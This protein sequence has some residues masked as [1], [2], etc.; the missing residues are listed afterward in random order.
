MYLS[1]A[2]QPKLIIG[3][4]QDMM[5]TDIVP[6]KYYRCDWPIG[7][8]TCNQSSYYDVNHDGT[9]DFYVFHAFVE[10]NLSSYR[11][12]QV[13]PIGNVE[14]LIDSMGIT[15]FNKGD[16]I[17]S[18]SS[19]TVD[20]IYTIVGYD[21]ISNPIFDTAYLPRS[22]WWLDTSHHGWE[23]TS[24]A[25]TGGSGGVCSGEANWAYSL[26]DT[27]YFAFRLI[28][29]SDTVYGWFKAY[30]N[31]NTYFNLIGES[32]A[33]TGDTGNYVISQIKELQKKSEISLYPNPVSQKLFIESPFRE[34]SAEV[35]SAE[36][37]KLISTKSLK[38]GD[39][40]D[41]SNLPAGLYFVV[42]YSGE[43]RRVKRFIKE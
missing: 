8:H 41:V 1:F 7:G 34:F 38:I 2:Q 32:F 29:N 4:Q 10:C 40:I 11:V 43:A 26:L 37:A 15:P 13:Y 21:S 25:H 22:A 19:H 17:V 31:D 18:D 33:I 27:N 9:N 36:G 14:F 16:S 28:E 39:N 20:N 42:I 6:D 35:I 30:S 24:V 5:F 23:Q 3:Q 12:W